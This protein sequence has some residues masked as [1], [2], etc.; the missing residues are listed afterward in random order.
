[1]ISGD[2]VTLSKI[3]TFFS[4]LNGHN[5][6]QFSKIRNFFLMLF[7]NQSQMEW[8]FEYNELWLMKLYNFYVAT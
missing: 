2:I 3:C 7:L 1:M 4:P 5:P 8:D 6:K